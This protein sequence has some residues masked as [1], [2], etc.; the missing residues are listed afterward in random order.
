[1]KK[2]ITLFSIALFASTFTSCK[3]DYTCECKI[4]GVVDNSLPLSNMKKDDA[5]AS[6]DFW[7]EAGEVCTLEKR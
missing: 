5:Q 6:C 3:K 1:M 4:D 7:Q 2:L